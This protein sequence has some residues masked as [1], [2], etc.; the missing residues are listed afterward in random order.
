[1]ILPGVKNAAGPARRLSAWNRL[2]VS[3]LH[4]EFRIEE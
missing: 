3:G 4:D 1:V 2:S